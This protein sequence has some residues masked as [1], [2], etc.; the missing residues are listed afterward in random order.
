MIQI[1]SQDIY[2]TFINICF[3]PAIGKAQKISYLIPMKLPFSRNH[4]FT[5]RHQ[6]LSKMHEVLKDD[7]DTSHLRIAVL[8]GLGGMGKTQLAN[9]Y[10]Y[11][12]E[13]DYT[14]TWWVNAKTTE[15]FSQG[16]FDIAQELIA[17]HARIR[18]HTGQ[19]PDFPWIA[20]A[21]GLPVDTV[22]EQ[23]QLLISQDLAQ[24]QVI[25]DAVKAWLAAEENHQWLLIIDNYDDLESVD[26]RGFLPTNSPG[27]AIITT[28]SPD[29]RRLGRGIEI[30]RVEQE[31][32]LEIL[33]KSANTDI[34]EFHK[35]KPFL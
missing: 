28:R 16:F 31:D 20:T 8:Y 25:I 13:G 15:T 22:N 29:T 30:A 9:Q 5:G 14:S 10:A 19:K 3:F 6:E 27:S 17:H 18:V 34:D 24:I 1:I 2:G 12:H 26:I 23:G 7:S 35:G 32:A 4:N 11:L 33:R 21:L